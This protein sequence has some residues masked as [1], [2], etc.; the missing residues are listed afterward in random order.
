MSIEAAAGARSGKPC[1]SVHNAKCDVFLKRSIEYRINFVKQHK[2]YYNCL[3]KGHSTNACQ[4]K[5]HC[6]RCQRAHH[7]V[8]LCDLDISDDMTNR[9]R[10]H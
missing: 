7:T 2:L 1:A 6:F 10:T 5:G 8:L 3:R 4:S 9:Q